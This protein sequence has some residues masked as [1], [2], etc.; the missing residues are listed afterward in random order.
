[1]AKTNGKRRDSMQMRLCT[2]PALPPATKVKMQ[3]ELAEWVED[4]QG[5]VDCLELLTTPGTVARI[6]AFDLEEALGVFAARLRGE[7]K[8]L[9]SEPWKEPIGTPEEI[10]EAADY[11]LHQ[12]EGENGS[13]LKVGT[14]EAVTRLLRVARERFG[15]DVQPAAEWK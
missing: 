1:M 5:W 2:L 11:L 10:V 8:T 12:R 3:P 7:T 13:D 4:L 6:L 14:E 9:W 15:S